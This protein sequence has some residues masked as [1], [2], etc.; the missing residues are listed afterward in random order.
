MYYISSF[1]L[2]PKGSRVLPLSMRYAS[3]VFCTLSPFNLMNSSR[4]SVM[5]LAEWSLVR[6]CSKTVVGLEILDG[7]SNG[8]Q[9]SLKWYFKGLF[10][11]RC[12][13]QVGKVTHLGGVACLSTP[14]HVHMIGGETHRGGL[15]GLPDQ[16]TLL[17]RVKFG[18]V[19]VSRLLNLPSLDMCHQICW[20]NN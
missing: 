4:M 20:L 15:R 3:Q 2:I 14:D 5:L 17:A 12:Q 6:K 13:P 10:T 9:C 7:L 1:F 11:R 16:V 19:K 18:H 8:L